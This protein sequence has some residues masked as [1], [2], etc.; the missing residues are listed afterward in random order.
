MQKDIRAADIRAAIPQDIRAAIPAA[1]PVEDA[2]AIRAR[3][4][5]NSP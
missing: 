1:I 3:I 2:P 5:A 4:L